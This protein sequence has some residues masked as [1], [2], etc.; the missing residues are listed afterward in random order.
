MVKERVP[1]PSLLPVAFIGPQLESSLI[2]LLSKSEAVLPHHEK[3]RPALL[4]VGSCHFLITE[5]L[6]TGGDSPI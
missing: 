6:T 1:G 3:K 2:Y 5:S 4:H